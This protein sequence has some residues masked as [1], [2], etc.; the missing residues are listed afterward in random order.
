[1]TGDCRSISWK[2]LWKGARWIV[3]RTQPNGQIMIDHR[4]LLCE[5]GA[6]LSGKQEG[7]EWGAQGEL[8]GHIPF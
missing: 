6:I 8:P 5:C 7:Q 1:M 4:K 3:V 2:H